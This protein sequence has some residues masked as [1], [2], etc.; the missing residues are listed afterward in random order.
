M[1]FQTPGACLVEREQ[2]INCKVKMY[3]GKCQC[4]WSSNISEWSII[5]LKA[6]LK[7][8]CLGQSYPHYILPQPKSSH[9]RHQ[10][11]FAVAWR[12]LRRMH[13]KSWTSLET[14]DSPGKHRLHTTQT[15]ASLHQAGTGLPLLRKH[16]LINLPSPQ[17]GHWLSPLLALSPRTLSFQG[18]AS[19]RACCKLW[20]WAWQVPPVGLAGV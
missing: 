17:R 15:M 3:R 8:P 5:K 2:C 1:L 12:Q 13:D 11:C 20:R 7:Q 10:K 4:T 6:Q 9:N 16:G 18:C 19:W 14:L